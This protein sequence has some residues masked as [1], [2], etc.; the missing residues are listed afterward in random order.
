MKG[1]PHAA[2]FSCEFLPLLIPM[3]EFSVPYVISSV[4]ELILHGLFHY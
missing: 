1:I 3:K 2:E 4:T